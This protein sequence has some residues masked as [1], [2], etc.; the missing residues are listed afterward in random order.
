M[1]SQSRLI[2]FGAERNEV[3]LPYLMA[4]SLSSRSIM[5]LQID[6]TPCV[7]PGILLPN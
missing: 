4:I 6:S 2:S 1:E 3:P 7:T 5:E